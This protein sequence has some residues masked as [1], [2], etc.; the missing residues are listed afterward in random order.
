MK[1]YII[2][3]LTLFL[4]FTYVSCEE[5]PVVYDNVN[6]Q[7]MVQFS[8]SKNTQPVVVEGTSFTEIT[9]YS[10]T[11]SNVERTIDIEIGDK[12][13]A[14]TNQYSIS[15][16]VIPS[17]S[18]EGKIRVKG[19]YENLSESGDV[20][21]VEINLVGVDSK[22]NV[23]VSNGTYTV[24]LFRFCPVQ[25]GTYKID[26]HDSYGDG[27]QTNGGNGGNGITATMVD[28]DGVETVVE[29]GMCTPYEASPYDN[30][31]GVPAT[32][33]F[34]DASYNLSVPDGTKDI[35]WNFPGDEY[36]EI[37]FEIYAPNGK[38]LF[39]S[40]EPGDQGAGILPPF[41]YCL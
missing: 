33:G 3:L 28:E 31:S 17:G 34:T 37:N 18:Y 41:I 24:S 15:N 22:S 36:K 7:T 10:T 25:I 12:T 6:G 4:T 9:V 16:L 26:M 40:G 39:A 20:A 19:V 2:G 32:S 8:G 35:I 38:L 1:K 30:C 13:N 27:W 11:V 21:V 29:F 14:T 5:E 23:V